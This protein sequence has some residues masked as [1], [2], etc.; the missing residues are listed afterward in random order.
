M[1]L[2]ENCELTEFAVWR[3]LWREKEVEEEE[4]GAG[5]REAVAKAKEVEVAGNHLRQHPRARGRK[6]EE[7]GGEADA[8]PPIGR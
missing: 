7:G 5:E 8:F 4:A 3:K 6:S 2:P 1:F